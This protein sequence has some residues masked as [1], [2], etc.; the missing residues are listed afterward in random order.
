MALTVLRTL[1]GG[2]FAEVGRPTV[3]STSPN[4]D[5]VAVG[6][7]DERLYWPG[8]SLFSDIPGHRLGLYRDGVCQ[9]L[10]EPSHPVQS[11]AFHP[12]LPLLA[13]GTGRYDG[14]YFFE[15]QLLLLDLITGKVIDTMRESREIRR[16]EWSDDGQTLRLLVA[17]VGDYELEELAHTHAYPIEVT[18]DDWMRW[19]QIQ[20]PAAANSLVECPVPTAAAPSPSG[21]EWSGRTRVW[22]VECLSDGRILAAL[23][24]REVECWAADG[25]LDWEIAEGSSGRQLV[26]AEDEATAWVCSEWPYDQ[27]RGAET[28]K[29]LVL[30]ATGRII[31]EVEY[32]VSTTMTAAAGWIALRGTQRTSSRLTFIG[33]DRQL[34]EGPELTGFDSLNHPFAIRRS[35]ELLFLA[36]DERTPHHNKWVVSADPVRSTVRRLFPLDWQGTRHLYGGPGLMLDGDLIHAATDH[37]RRPDGAFVVRRRLSDGSPRW[38]FTAGTRITA[39]DE[40]AG[41][42]YCGLTS[43]D[44]V[45]LDATDGTVRWRMRLLL[46]GQPAVPLSL[47][48]A[49]PDRLVIGTTD[50]RIADCRVGV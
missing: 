9:W 27:S 31:D 15:G 20:L 33:P 28:S 45:A 23:D 6:G 16:V 11:T 48:T 26:V 3:A 44:L 32:D 8:N 5:L 43:G 50:G 38:V 47:A 42:L 49:A 35:T 37:D 7:E 17:P 30:L 24:G 40:L 19:P 34:S 39:L 14:G 25:R 12:E 1:G 46:G 21:I 13:I 10:I 22:A 36:G 2:A 29:D 41:T 4:G 18:G